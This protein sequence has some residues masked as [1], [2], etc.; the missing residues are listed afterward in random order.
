[1]NQNWPPL[2]LL[3]CDA[4]TLASDGGAEAIRSCIEA[5]E[6]KLVA[7]EDHI[8]GLPTRNYFYYILLILLVS[9]KKQNYLQNSWEEKHSTT[10]ATYQQRLGV[11]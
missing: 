10:T 8:P 6:E 5:K 7:H 2:Q 9:Q 1:M 11:Y 3:L 4:A